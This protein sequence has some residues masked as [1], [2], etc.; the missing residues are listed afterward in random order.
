MKAAEQGS[1]R[2]IIENVPNSNEVTINVSWAGKVNVFYVKK[3][4][5][6]GLKSINEVETN[7]TTI[8]KLFF[9]LPTRFVSDSNIKKLRAYYFEGNVEFFLNC[10]NKN[11][12]NI[13]ITIVEK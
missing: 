3:K 9:F 13:V 2:H 1:F 6:L 11:G 4:K 8:K 10:E 7:S 5:N 12:K